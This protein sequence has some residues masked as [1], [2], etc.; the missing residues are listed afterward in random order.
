MDVLNIGPRILHPIAISKYCTNVLR[1]Q[2]VLNSYADI[3]ACL[4]SVHLKVP[5]QFFLNLKHT[6]CLKSLEMNSMYWC[7]KD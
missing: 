2:S 3:G 1:H 7:T 6:V 4:L 5:N